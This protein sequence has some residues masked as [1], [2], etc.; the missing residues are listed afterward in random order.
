MSLITK[1]RCNAC[2]GEVSECKGCGGISPCK[3]DDHGKRYRRL[4]LGNGECE[5][6]S[7]EAAVE[8]WKEH[9]GQA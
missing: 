9:R 8:R 6:G 5:P 7:K 4:C 2:Q 1:G 3:C